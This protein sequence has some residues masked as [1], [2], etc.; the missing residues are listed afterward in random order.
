MLLV[1]FRSQSL[2]T[3]TV[4]FDTVQLVFGVSPDKVD[5]EVLVGVQGSH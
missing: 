4:I 1:I 3:A 2:E 5:K